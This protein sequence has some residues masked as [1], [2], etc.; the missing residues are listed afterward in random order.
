[1]SKKPLPTHQK[2]CR[3]SQAALFS[4]ASKKMLASRCLARPTKGPIHEV[5]VSPFWMDTTEVTNAQFRKFVEATG[6]KTVAETPFKQEDY[7]KAPPEALVPAGY[8]FV[9]PDES[10]DLRRANHNMWWRFTPGASWRTPG[11][12]GTDIEGK[13]DHPV[14]CITYPD[15]TA[16]AKW[17]G[18]RLPTEAEWEF[19]ARGGLE[20]KTYS[21]GDELMPDGKFMANYWQGGFPNIN[22]AEDGFKTTSPAKSYPPNQFGL[23]DMTGNVWEIVNDLY[24][25][26]YYYNSPRQDP[27]GPK[28]SPGRN[29]ENPD[30]EGDGTF[31]E[32]V[33]RGGS[34]LCSPDYCIGYRPGARQTTDNIT[35]SNHT[36]FRC[37]K[38]VKTAAKTEK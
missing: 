36:G 32:H 15:A 14:V 3:G 6:Y 33:M 20:Q 28:T 11:G 10:I 18:K 7:P 8:I 21:W 1:M 16:Y 35:A 24:H 9:Q 22:S 30:E 13:D 34:Y 23:Y 17:A 25:P 5:E 2:E 26:D 4:W 38:D 19:A 12:P 27:P 37:V 31:P 29:P